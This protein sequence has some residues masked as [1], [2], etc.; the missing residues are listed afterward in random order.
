LS[1]ANSEP[2]DSRVP[3]NSTYENVEKLPTDF[4]GL[5]ALR[6]SLRSRIDK[7]QYEEIPKLNYDVQD[8]E[9]YAKQINFYKSDINRLKNKKNLAAWEQETLSSDQSNLDKY[10]L[11]LAELQKSN[12]KQSLQDLNKELSK[13]KEK[14]DIVENKINELLSIEI[15]QQ[16]F[17]KAMSLTFAMLVG[18]VI[19]GFFV[20]AAKD[21]KVRV[22]IFSGQA[23]IQ[24]VTLFSLV[25]AIILFGIT[26]VLGG[27]ELSALLGGISGYI[28]GRSVA[29]NTE[30]VKKQAENSA[31]QAEQHE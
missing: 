20:I 23:G 24:F 29:S 3:N 28:L 18:L 25:I 2:V 11:Q 5:R 1:Q 9:S 7:L 17:K 13:T 21:Q 14:L 15:S 4:A 26:D 19:V 10:N 8:L 31:A 27:K 30:A 12:P 16:N 22:T 6:V